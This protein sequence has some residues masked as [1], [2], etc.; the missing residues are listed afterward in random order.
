[1]CRQSTCPSTTRAREGGVFTAGAGNQGDEPAAALV[2]IRHVLGSGQLA[3]GDVEEVVSP[4]QLAQQVP[5]G[6]VGAVVGG[7]ATLDPEVHRHGT[8]ATD[9]EDVE[10]LLEVGAVIPCCG[11]R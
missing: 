1:M 8:V 10:Q 9:G 11:P 2:D 5:G 7:V 3:V 4:G 6:D